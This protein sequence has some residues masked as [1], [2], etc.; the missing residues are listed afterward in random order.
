MY[1][2][3][4]FMES[5]GIGLGIGLFLVAVAIVVMEVDEPGAELESGAGAVTTTTESGP[6]VGHDGLLLEPA[7]LPG[8]QSSLLVDS[9][10]VG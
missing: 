3:R 9:G 10:R 8:R 4:Q 7:G 5:L 2:I 1:A 6:A